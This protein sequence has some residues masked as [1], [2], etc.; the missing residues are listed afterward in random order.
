MIR[1]PPR[2]TLFPYTTLFRSSPFHPWN[3]Q[4]VPKPS[5][6]S[7]KDKYTW[8]CTPRWDRNVVE[9]GAYARLWLTALARKQPQNDFMEPTG[10]G[11]TMRIPHG[12]RPETEVR[13]EVPEHWNAFERNR[14]RAYHYLFS[15]L[16]AMHNLLEAY[17][18]MKR[19][20]TRVA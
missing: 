18:L 12:F 1:L 2:S 4:T 6:K 15:Q 10:D 9:A 17:R 19:G 7:W 13:W 16:V 5:E 20:E 8:A 11:I 3:K 14:G